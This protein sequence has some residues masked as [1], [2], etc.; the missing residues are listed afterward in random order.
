MRLSL[1]SRCMR[2][3]WVLSVLAALLLSGCTDALQDAVAGRG[4]GALDYLL[5]CA[6]FNICF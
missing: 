2:P 3:G 4:T 1:A 6:N 5:F